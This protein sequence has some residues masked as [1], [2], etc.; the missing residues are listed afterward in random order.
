MKQVKEKIIENE[1]EGRRSTLLTHFYQ[2]QNYFR[3]FLLYYCMKTVYAFIEDESWFTRNISLGYD[4][5]L[6]DF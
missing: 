1:W 5:V 3:E 4:F 6:T 2:Q